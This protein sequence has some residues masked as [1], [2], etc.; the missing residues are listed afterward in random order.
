[1]NDNGE[2]DKFYD[3]NEQKQSF[4]E[5]LGNFDDSVSYIPVRQ[6]LEEGSP[7]RVNEDEDFTMEDNSILENLRKKLYFNETLSLKNFKG[8]NEVLI[9]PPKIKSKNKNPNLN[10]IKKY[11]KNKFKY[12]FNLRNHLTYKNVFMTPRNDMDVLILP[13]T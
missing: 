3:E 9:Y 12:F 4:S 5:Q 6:F 10:S 7:S 11:I 13:H 1:M 8:Q 2:N